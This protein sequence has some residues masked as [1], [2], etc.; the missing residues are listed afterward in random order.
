MYSR[1]GTILYNSPCWLI[2]ERLKVR[3]VIESS[4]KGREPVQEFYRSHE[5]MH[6]PSN[7]VNVWGSPLSVALH[8]GAY[9]TQHEALGVVHSQK[10]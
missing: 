10:K 7:D 3:A 2:R 1:V 8:R 6:N 5:C 9:M 4:I